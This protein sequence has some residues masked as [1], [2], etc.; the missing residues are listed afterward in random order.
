MAIEAGEGVGIVAQLLDRDAQLV[1]VGR[2]QCPQIGAALEDLLQAPV[3]ELGREGAHGPV[4]VGRAR[5]TQPGAGLEPGGGFQQQGAVTFG[6]QGLSGRGIGLGAGRLQPRQQGGLGV[7][8]ERRA[9]GLEGLGDEDVEVAGAVHDAAQP[10]ELGLH[11]IAAAVGAGGAEAGHGAAQAAKAD[12]QT[13]DRLGVVTGG[14]NLT[15]Q[16]RL[17]Q[18]GVGDGAEGLARALAGF[19]AVGAFMARAL[20]VGQGEA[21]VGLAGKAEGQRRDLGQAPGQDE[22][23]GDLAPDQLQLQLTDRGVAALGLRLALV[24]ADLDARAA[25]VHLPRAAQHADGEGRGDQ[26]AV[27]DGGGGGLRQGLAVDGEALGG[28]FPFAAREAAAVGGVARALDGLDEGLALLAHT[29]GE[30]GFAQVAAGAVVIDGGEGLGL[31]LGELQGVGKRPGA[32]VADGELQ[33]DLTVRHGSD[34]GV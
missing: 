9:A 1:T 29:Q 5:A 7:G 12:A 3:H 8:I 15:G 4:A 21:P 14:E 24:Q 25:L 10:F 30:A 31:G 6:S 20:A 34:P 23:V 18:G 19:Q 26:R 33:L 28:G 27:D 17:G 22:E 11:P 16:A 2:S 13:V 32:R